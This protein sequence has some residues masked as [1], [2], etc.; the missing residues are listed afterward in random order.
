MNS[1]GRFPTYLGPGV[2]IIATHGAP[3]LSPASVSPRARE[4]VSLLLS[5]AVRDPVVAQ[6]LRAVF[7]SSSQPHMP[8][9]RLD[10]REV[11]R[12]MVDL[13][14]R[15]QV[16]LAFVSAA[17]AIPKGWKKYK[18]GDRIPAP[19]KFDKGKGKWV[20]VW[21]ITPTP[22][23]G[24]LG[25]APSSFDISATGTKLTPISPGALVAEELLTMLEEIEKEVKK[26]EKEQQ[27]TAKLQK[28]DEK[29]LAEAKK[30]RDA[31]K[32]KV[33]AAKTED[34][35]RNAQVELDN[36]EEWIKHHELNIEAR[37]AH[38]EK[39]KEKVKEL[40]AKAERGIENV[41]L[42]EQ[43]HLDINAFTAERANEL[44]MHEP[45]PIK[46]QKIIDA[47]IDI[48]E[49]TDD[50]MDKLIN[51]I[52]FGSIEDDKKL[53]DWIS[54]TSSENYRSTIK[55]KFKAKGL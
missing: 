15:G 11:I 26:A 52:T 54:E 34:E 42:H 2:S 45:D 7:A 14:V 44:L 21:A 24:D 6:Q 32:K 48:T 9:L 13:V 5:S 12:Q 35:K 51:P 36:A 41:R 4:G 38:I 31:A 19:V 33:D 49:E 46:R 55:D 22:N 29:K 8:V 16:V 53:A 30:E 43:T 3:D 20:A 37:K 18:H 23:P 47:A 28:E 27:D 40:R 50:V 17:A 39:Q 1:K 10:D 25:A